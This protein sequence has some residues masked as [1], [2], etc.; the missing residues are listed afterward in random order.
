MTDT[1]IINANL[2]LH[3]SSLSK[4]KSETEISQISDQ[5]GQIYLPYSQLLQEAFPDGIIPRELI[6]EIN[7]WMWFIMV[8]DE[9]NKRDN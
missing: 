9:K 5:D 8:D 4:R 6:Y 2:E 3:G 1:D 7:S